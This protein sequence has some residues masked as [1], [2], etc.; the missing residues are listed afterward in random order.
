MIL[1]LPTVVGESLRVSQQRE[2]VAEARQR[3]AERRYRRTDAR[4]SLLV[5]L[6]HARGCGGAEPRPREPGPVLQGAAA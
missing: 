1:G 4:L 3:A 5:G 6:Y 2:L